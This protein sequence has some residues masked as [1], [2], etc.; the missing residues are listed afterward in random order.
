MHRQASQ[1]QSSYQQHDKQHKKQLVQFSH[2]YMYR[3]EGH[4]NAGQAHLYV[5]DHGVY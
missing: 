2:I 4:R 3:F 1:C 5:V